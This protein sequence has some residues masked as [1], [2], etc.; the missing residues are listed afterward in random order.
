[1]KKTKATIIV[2]VLLAC[3]LLATACASN[4][5]AAT[6]TPEPAAT[7]TPVASVAPV[8]PSIAPSSD[9]D[10]IP[11]GFKEAPM[12][13]DRVAK[14]E[15]P[16]VD[17]RLPKNPLVVTPLDGVGTYGG[18]LRNR[19]SSPGDWGDIWHNTFPHLIWFNSDTSEYVPELAESFEFNADY[20]ELTL[21][22]REGMRWSDGDPF[23]ADDIE[24]WWKDYKY[25]PLFN[26]NLDPPGDYSPGGEAMK[27]EKLD[28]YTIKYTFAVPYPSILTVLTSWNGMAG[29]AFLPSHLIRAVHPDYV[30]DA[31]AK[32]AELYGKWEKNTG[33]EAVDFIANLMW[34]G[35]DADCILPTL[36]MWRQTTVSTT[37]VYFER[38]PYYYAVDTEGN[39]LPYI[40]SVRCEV[41]PDNEV[42]ALNIMQGKYDFGKVGTDKLE[43]IKAKEGD[44]NYGVRL[45]TGDNASGPLVAFNQNHK[46]PIVAEIFRDVRFRQA[47]SVAINRAEINDLIYNGYGTPTQAT[48]NRTASFFDQKWA[49]AYAQYDPDLA[50]SLLD[51][52]GLDKRD[53]EGYRLRSDG[54]VLTFTMELGDAKQNELVAKYWKDVGVKA[55]VNIIDVNLYWSR[56]AASDLD[57]GVAALDNSVEFKAFSTISK[58]SMTSDDLG[59]AEL[60]E[61]WYI[62][63]GAEGEV[64]PDAVQKFFADWEAIQSATGA[65]Y[66]TLAKSIFDFYAE[67]LYLIGTVGYGL[68]A[69]YVCNDVQNVP[70]NA[71]FMD[72]TNWWLLTRPDQWFLTR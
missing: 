68:N 19:I 27:V 58:Y 26:V 65:E 56:S 50:N 32:A 6:N 33:I 45:Y 69:V 41:V 23:D 52:M 36:G 28:A 15:L 8:L 63:K 55:E 72:P 2:S 38:N 64:P 71:L 39:Q 21:H 42:Y 14:G 29:R 4:P 53:G 47:M 17:E 48:I 51:E 34:P 66:E 35:G 67:N 1:M 3:M 46:D 20:T 30:A 16:P 22:L 62:T 61:K 31:D 49:D 60:W 18:E 10:P 54:K 70:Q 40:D 57:L 44:G 24:C 11:E 12:L 43:L 25:N 7:P 5:P 37:E 59:Y 13:A 9:P